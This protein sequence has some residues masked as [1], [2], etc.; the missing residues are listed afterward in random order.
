MAKVAE[1]IGKNYEE[2]VADAL[3][4][5]GLTKEQVSIEIIEEPKKRIF[6]ILDPRQIKVRVTEISMPAQETT[7]AAGEKKREIKE[8]TEED[9]NIVK[10][11]VTKFLNDY[12][13]RFGLTLE[14]NSYVE[15]NI[16]KFDVTGE[17]T[18]I[19]I[20]YRGE[21]MEALQ[22]IAS[23][24]GNK[25]M[26]NYVR[27]IIDVGGYRKKRIKALEELA[28]KRANIVVSKR[29]SITL[30]PMNPFERKAIHNA[31]QNH[32]KVKTVS[33][34]EEPYRKVVISLK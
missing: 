4:K 32:P 19:I 6:S 27:I 15:D 1:G 16:L 26:K 7:A 8:F 23:T 21:T 5:V 20:G 17:D 3:S 34:G 2:A 24:I 9:A 18:G 11:R 28:L 25:N 14:I 29:K 13:A 30:E 10:E 33:T 31:L 12:F 22:M